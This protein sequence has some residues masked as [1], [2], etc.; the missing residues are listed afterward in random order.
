[1]QTG[2]F[3]YR[4]GGYLHLADRF[5]VFG[6]QRYDNDESKPR[7]ERR[8]GRCEWEEMKAGGGNQ[9]GGRAQGSWCH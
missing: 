1:M 7:L 6:D 9:R 2:A 4:K 8:G 3:D 5:Q